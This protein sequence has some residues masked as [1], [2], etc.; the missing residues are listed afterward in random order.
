[1]EFDFEIAHC[2]EK[3]H[4]AAD[5]MSGLTQ[6]ATDETKEIADINRNVLAYC[7]DR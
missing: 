1:M 4:K 5:A 7:I 6:K 3:Y 2:M